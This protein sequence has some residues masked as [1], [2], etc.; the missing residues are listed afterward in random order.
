MH[1]GEI[2]ALSQQLAP[3]AQHLV[4]LLRAA[5][6]GIN[7][8]NMDPWFDGATQELCYG[9]FADQSG[10][11]IVRLAH[12]RIREGA[13]WTRE[14]R[15]PQVTQ[16]TPVEAIRRSWDND[17]SV[18]INVTLDRS[19]AMQEGVQSVVADQTNWNHSWGLGSS[20]R[21]TVSTKATAGVK[22]GVFSGSAEVSASLEAAINATYSGSSGGSHGQTDTTSSTMTTTRRVQQTFTVPSRCRFTA[23]A[24]Y[25]RQTLRVPYKDWLPVDCGF[26]VPPLRLHTGTIFGDGGDHGRYMEQVTL[27]G[28]SLVEWLGG[29]YGEPKGGNGFRPGLNLTFPANGQETEV[30]RLVDQLRDSD[31]LSIERTGHVLWQQAH[32]FSLDTHEEPL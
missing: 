7:P 25:E 3:A 16:S 30:S 11:A 32:G 26:K 24:T 8:A 29:F 27:H 4:A 17:S 10:L 21:A 19:V 14:L 22:A 6:A 23:L 28:E 15:D 5:G 1:A 12:V 31:L 13:G 2:R 18:P 9:R 20:L